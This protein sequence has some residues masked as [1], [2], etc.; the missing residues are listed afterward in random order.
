[1]Q[2]QE[3]MFTCFILKVK[4]PLKRF[5]FRSF[6]LQTCHFVDT[7]T[8]FSDYAFPKQAVTQ[9]NNTTDSRLHTTE[10]CSPVAAV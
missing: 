3:T 10:T 5:S 6:F 4:H 8:L 1:M 7:L 9:Q 2:Q